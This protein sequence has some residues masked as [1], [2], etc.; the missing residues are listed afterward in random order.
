MKRLYFT[1]ILPLLLGI[2]NYWSQCNQ[3]VPLQVVNPSFEGTPSKHV[4]PSPWNT[5]GVTPDTQPGHWGVTLPPSN[6]NS[7]VGFVNGGSSWLEGAS[8][9]LSGNMIANVTYTFTIDLA[10]TN[11]N[12]GGINN[13]SRCGIHLYGGNSLCATTS[14]LWSSP[15]ITHLNWQT[16][17]VTFTPTQNFSHVY[18]R[19]HGGHLGY[20]LVDNITPFV[21]QGVNITSHVSGASENCSFNL[22]G[23]V[24]GSS[25]DSVVISGNFVETPLTANLTGNNWT[26]HLTFN[27]PGTETVTATSY[28][29]VGGV[30][31]CVFT[32]V[33]LT[34]APPTSTFTAASVCENQSTSFVD[35]SSSAGQEFVTAWQWNF[36]D[37]NTSTQQNPTHT[38]STA[39]TYNVQLSVTTNNNCVGSTTIPYTVHAL[40]NTNAGA[41]FTTNCIN[42]THTLS[43]SGGGN[44]SWSPS[45]GLSNASIANPVANPTSNTTYTL[46]VTDGNGCVNTDD[47]VINVDKGI[48]TVGAGTDFTTNCITPTHTLNGTGSGSYSWSPSSGLSNANIANPVANPS[49]TTNYTLTVT[50]ANGCTNTE[51]ILITVDKG[52]PSVDA[53]TDFTTTCTT[54]TYTIN[55]SGTGSFQWSPISGLSDATI[56]TP[57]ASPSTTTTYTLTTTGANGCTNSDAVTITVDQNYPIVPPINDITLDCNTSS[58]T[59][60]ASGGNTYSWSTPTGGGSAQSLSVDYTNLAG[61]YVVTVTAANGCEVVDSS[62][63]YVD[64]IVPTAHAGLDSV[65]TCT[66]LVIDLN[67]NNSSTGNDYTYNW[68]TTNGNITQ[69]TTT[70][71]PTINQEGTYLLTVLDTINHCWKTDSVVIGIDTIHPVANAGV[72]SIITCNIPEINLS[73]I[74]SSSGNFSYQWVTTDGS[75]VNSATTTTPLINAGGTYLLTVTNNYNGCSSSDQVFIDEDITANVEILASSIQIDSIFGIAPHV[76]DFSWVGDE[77]SVSWDFGDNNYSTDSSITHSYDLRGNYTAI[78]VLT[79]T[80]GCVAYDTVYVDIDGREIIFPNVFTP[81]GDGQNDIFTFRGER[82]K[83]FECSIYNRWGQVVYSWDA[84]VGGWDG[85]SFAGKELPA[86]Q[87]FYILKAIDRDDQSIEQTGTIM[88]M[89]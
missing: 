47:V 76:V 63:L 10:A 8:Q 85:R 1:I 25:T 18:F 87:Y 42:P 17:T 67:G 21:A 34:L 70:T 59:F 23:T 13:S 86:G 28:Y 58:G 36:G 22:N 9:Q 12:Q 27:N 40:P 41:D 49:S 77:G 54:P 19:V 29:T 33:D 84:P 57:V 5:C 75:I 68:N 48:P 56:A 24:S 50:G 80:E 55:G 11:A 44:Y 37:G 2:N 64:T 31:Y 83:T 38:Y 35:A 81:N 45:S 66:A 4:T 61:A 15:I 20:V 51:D 7:Y 14:L 89:K 82:I 43:G 72:D 73:G 78:I 69:G 88:L 32:T 71:T 65:L 16:Y 30:Q 46:T 74:G 3:Q 60:S 6:G 39:G 79:D 53:G 26:A 52:L 62:N